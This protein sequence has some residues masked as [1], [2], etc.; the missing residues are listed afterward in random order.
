MFKVT[1]MDW[2]KE[3]T[4]ARIMRGAE[5]YGRAV[6]AQAHEDIA[7]AKRLVE[8]EEA[9][10]EERELC[11]VRENMVVVR[12]AGGGLLL[13]AP[14]K[15]H[16]DTE[17]GPF[18]RN[19]GPVEWIVAPSSEHNLQLPGIIKQFPE[20]KIIASKT[21]EKKLNFVNALPR[22]K[23]DFD[24]TN[25]DELEEV[26]KVLG[27]QG[28][29]M[30]F[31][32]GD[33]ATNALF[34]VAH[35]VALECDI[36]YTHDDGEGFL[37]MDQQEFRALDPKRFWERLFKFRLLSPANSP[38]GFLPPYRYWAMDPRG[39]WPLVLTP[40]AEDGSSA[41]TMAASLRSALA[42]DFDTAT[43]VHFSGM[44]ADKFRRS[45]DANW[46]WLDGKSLLS[47]KQ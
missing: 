10:A 29:D 24:Y 25:K 36:L 37:F 5:P 9:G 21:T 35:K 47:A 14:V 12:L 15:I 13:Y 11:L 31:I 43:G 42:T 17:L 28:M 30:V 8:V 4:F 7:A 38:H 3:E 39:V 6:S 1:G 45:V 27:S 2:S 22:G 23:V 26:K 41:R 18:I 19:L 20:A 40:P 32:D 16:E 44:E 46:N 33:C 34:C